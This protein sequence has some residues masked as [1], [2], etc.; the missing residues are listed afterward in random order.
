MLYAGPWSGPT[1]H[2]FT[3]VYDS[4]KTLKKKNENIKI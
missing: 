1:S 2:S 4:T 3:T